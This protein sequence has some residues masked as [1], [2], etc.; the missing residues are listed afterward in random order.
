MTYLLNFWSQTYRASVSS[1]KQLIERAEQ[2][3]CERSTNVG[4]YQVVDGKA[5]LLGVARPGPKQ[6]E[7]SKTDWSQ[8]AARSHHRR[9]M[10]AFVKSVME[11]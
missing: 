11:A 8:V 5:V 10:N 6:T 7:S 4:Y 3:A 1:E 2:L 9:Q